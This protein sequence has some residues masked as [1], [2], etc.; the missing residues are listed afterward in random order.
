MTANVVEIIC[1]KF[2]IDDVFQQARQDDVGDE[3][4]NGNS[5]TEND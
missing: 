1:G 5:F 3:T 2:L 4:V